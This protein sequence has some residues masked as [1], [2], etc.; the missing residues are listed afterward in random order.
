MTQEVGALARRLSLPYY[1]NALPAHDQFHANRVRD[2]SVRLADECGETVDRAVLSAAAWFH[3]IGRPLE[4]AGE[5][6]NHDEWAAAKAEELL[7]SDAV[8]TDQINAI[9]HCIRTHS[10]RGSSPEPETLEAQLLFDADKLEAAGAR[11]IIR[12]SCIVGERSGR[13]GEKYAVI[14]DVAASDVNINESDHPDV[15]LLREWMKERL[16]QLY[17]P[18]GRRLG[19]SRWSFM[20]EFFTQFNSEIGVDGQK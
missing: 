20:E 14:D 18:P 7:K 11:G 4:R 15:T 9:K 2:L 17:T 6:D 5:I 19:T 8:P 10:I 13:A 16:D 1:E 12:L 3:D